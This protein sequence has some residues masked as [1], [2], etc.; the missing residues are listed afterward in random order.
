MGLILIDLWVM[1]R[2]EV[3]N[4]FG[5][6]RES[7]YCEEGLVEKTMETLERDEPMMRLSMVSKDE[8]LLEQIWNRYSLID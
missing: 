2:I 5:A 1:M 8:E 3:L 4:L 6:M 7:C